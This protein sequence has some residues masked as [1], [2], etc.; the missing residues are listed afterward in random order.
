MGFLRGRGRCPLPSRAPRR[1]TGERPPFPRLDV[2]PARPLRRVAPWPSFQKKPGFLL[3]R[4][5]GQ[6]SAPAGFCAER[7]LSPSERKRGASWTPQLLPCFSLGVFPAPGC[8]PASFRSGLERLLREA[9][10]SHPQPHTS[11]PLL[12]SLWSSTC[13][14]YLFYPVFR[15]GVKDPS[16]PAG[17]ADGPLAVC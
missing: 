8:A 5:S 9:F 15:A 11:L 4:A 14:S 3:L 16:V 7:S 17:V 2:G 13:G 12:A 1:R 10:Q 6:G